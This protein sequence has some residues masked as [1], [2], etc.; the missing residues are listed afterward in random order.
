MKV[1]LPKVASS[2]FLEESGSIRVNSTV[3]LGDVITVV[4][5]PTV[6]CLV[7]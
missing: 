5:S 7:A 4:Q 1:S 2:M 6:L 3:V